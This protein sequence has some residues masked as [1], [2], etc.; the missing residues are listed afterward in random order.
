MKFIRYRKWEADNSTNREESRRIENQTEDM[1]EAERERDYG[2][3]RHRRARPPACVIRN[4]KPQVGC[5]PCGEPSF[6]T[7]CCIPPPTEERE[8]VWTNPTSRALPQQPDL[9]AK[10]VGREEVGREGVKMESSGN[11]PIMALSRAH[12]SFSLRQTSMEQHRR[13]GCA[14]A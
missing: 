1:H 13:A 5:M 6:L 8:L 14:P 11:S 9:E 10:K 2:W 12:K 4:N 7:C 3:S